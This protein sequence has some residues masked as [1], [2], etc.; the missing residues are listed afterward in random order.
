M[1]IFRNQVQPLFTNLFNFVIQFIEGLFPKDNIEKSST[2]RRLLKA[3]LEEIEKQN[4][5]SQSGMIVGDD[6]VLDENDLRQD[7]IFSFIKD[8]KVDKIKT[9]FREFNRNNYPQDLNVNQ[10]LHQL[11]QKKGFTKPDSKIDYLAFEYIYSI[12]TF[13]LNNS[14]F[15]QMYEDKKCFGLHVPNLGIVANECAEGDDTLSHEVMHSF[16][17]FLKSKGIFKTMSPVLFGITHPH[18]ATVELFRN[19]CLAYLICNPGRISRFSLDHAVESMTQKTQKELQDMGIGDLVKMVQI[20]QVVDGNR[21]KINRKQLTYIALINP[22]IGSMSNE[23]V[24][25]ING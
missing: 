12:P 15:V 1:E 14:M 22:T 8:D 11:L 21:G 2:V 3:L 6:G 16:V 4:K 25:M 5:S 9:E 20:A 13:V 17:R 24:K 18:S 7:R 23:I 10:F 19:E